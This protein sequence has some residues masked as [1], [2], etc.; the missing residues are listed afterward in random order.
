MLLSESG[1][2][3]DQLAI[4]YLRHFIQYIKAGLDTPKKLLLIDGHASHRTPD[5]VLL[6]HKYQILSYAF[7]SHLTHVMQPLDVGIFQPYKHWHRKAIQHA[8]RNLNIDYN[9]TSFLRDLTGIR[10]NTFKIGTVKNAWKKTGIWP[11]NCKQTLTQMKIYTREP[12]PPLSTIPTT[13]RKFHESERGLEYW[14]LRIL[15]LLS[16]PSR[17]AFNSWAKGTQAVLA[18]GNIKDLE[19]EAL[20]LRVQDQ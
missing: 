13:P 4:I 17:R 9:I 11:L 8:L 19:F 7:P 10:H 15:E 18:G 12:A 16:S 14:E 3:N 1:Y 2:T 5:F 6:A 20:A